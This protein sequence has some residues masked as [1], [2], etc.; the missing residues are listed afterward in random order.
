MKCIVVKQ[1]PAS[2]ILDWYIQLHLC[3]VLGVKGHMHINK[4]QRMHR[5]QP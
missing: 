5:Q 1:G 2:A 4:L 3:I